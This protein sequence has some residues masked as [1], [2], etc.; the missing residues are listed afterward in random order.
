MITGATV[1]IR[2]RCKMSIKGAFR[3]RRIILLATVGLFS[4]AMASRAMPSY[5]STSLEINS[6]RTWAPSGLENKF[7]NERLVGFDQL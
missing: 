3:S 2:A 5:S 7:C 4:L 1:S 6:P